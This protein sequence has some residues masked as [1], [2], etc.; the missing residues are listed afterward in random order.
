[1]SVH[2]V[3][4][5][6][7]TYPHKC[8]AASCFQYACLVSVVLLDHLY[9]F[10]YVSFCLASLQACQIDRCAF[11]ITLVFTDYITLFDW[12]GQYC[13]HYAGQISRDDN[14]SFLNVPRTG[15]QMSRLL[16]Q[17]VSQ[18]AQVMSIF[19]KH[20]SLPPHIFQTI[21]SFALGLYNLSGT[22]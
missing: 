5:D 20:L 9:G 12:V 19:P 18:R 15:T 21:L 4:L 13:N 17:R 1:M 8:L 6:S 3:S 11:Q 7:L 14:H 16:F 22:K 10:W 2:S